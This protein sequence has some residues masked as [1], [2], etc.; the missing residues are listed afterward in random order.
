MV[1]AKQTEAAVGVHGFAPLWAVAYVAKSAKWPSCAETKLRRSVFMLA[2]FALSFVFANFGIA[3]A[4]KMPMITTTINSSIR[5]KPLRLLILPP[6]EWRDQRTWLSCETR[7]NWP[8]IRQLIC[9]PPVPRLNRCYDSYL[10]IGCTASCRPFPI[11]FSRILQEPAPEGSFAQA[12][13][14]HT[15]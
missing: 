13:V 3:I 7:C 8:G 5:V 15:T 1:C 11:W 2:I 6:V 12:H 9:H 10:A 4:A 14:A